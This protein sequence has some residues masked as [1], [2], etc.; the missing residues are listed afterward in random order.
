MYSHAYS[1]STIPYDKRYFTGRLEVMAERKGIP[2]V[3]LAIL[4]YCEHWADD[5]M[6]HAKTNLEART[7]VAE[8]NLHR[9]KARAEDSRRW[10]EHGIPSI[11]SETIPA[12]DA[13]E[14]LAWGHL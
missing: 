6:L 3:S 13:A 7:F 10:L 14:L 8:G 2:L 12:D 5:D 11:Y 4:D 1:Y 9:T